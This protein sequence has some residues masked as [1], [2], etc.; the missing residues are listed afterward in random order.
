MW[1][2]LIVVAV[3]AIASATLNVF[4]PRVLGN[5]TNII[6]NGVQNHQVHYHNRFGR[7]LAVA[8]KW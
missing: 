8:V 4:G 1:V 2:V 6:V 5:G 7:K 3:V